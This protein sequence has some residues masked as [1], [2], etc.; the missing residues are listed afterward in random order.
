VLGRNPREGEASGCRRRWYRH[1]NS[2]EGGGAREGGQSGVGV[3]GVDE[4]AW[5]R[6]EQLGRRRGREGGPATEVPHGAGRRHVAWARPAGDNPTVSRPAATRMRRAWAA[7]C[8]SDSSALAPTG[9]TP[10]AERVRRCGWR[11]G[12]PEKKA[13]GR[14]Q[15]NSKVLH[16]FELVLNS[17][18]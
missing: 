11:V 6:F 16:L 13:W 18:N 7:R 3:E 9:W 12:R 14:A 8:C 1:R 4:R 5:S 15:M 17:L 10:V 2:G